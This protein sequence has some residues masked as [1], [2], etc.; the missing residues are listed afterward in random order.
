MF[1]IKLQL[2][3]VAILAGPQ[4]STFASGIWSIHLSSCYTWPPIR[5]CGYVAVWVFGAQIISLRGVAGK[6]RRRGRE[7]QQDG[8]K[9]QETW[10]RRA[11][12]NKGYNFQL[13]N[14]RVSGDPMLVE[15]VCPYS[16]FNDCQAHYGPIGLHTEGGARRRSNWLPSD[17]QVGVVPR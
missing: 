16:Y 3:V 11:L 9:V 2:R 7:D 12:G 14:A 4:I 13:C 5:Y 10:S 6:H 8:S 15:P 1:I 17:F